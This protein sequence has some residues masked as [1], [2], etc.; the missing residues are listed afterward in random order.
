MAYNNSSGTVLLPDELLRVQ[1]VTSGILSG[2]LSYSDGADIINVPRV[3]NATNNA[4]LT[5]VDG[6]ANSLICES[7]LTFDG[8]TLTIVG[9]LTASADISGSSFHTFTTVIDETHISSSLNISGAAFYG[10]GSK[11]TGISAGGSGGGIF[12]EIDNSHAYTTSSVQI[13]STATPAHTMSVEGTSLLSGA[14]AVD[15]AITP[16]V[17]NTYDLGSSAKPWR[18]LYVSSSTI[19]LGTDTLSVG[20]DNN[21]KF[22]SGSTN[23]GFDVG[24]MNFKNTGIF[25]DPGRIFQLRAYQMRFYGGIAYVRQVVADDYSIKD[26]DYLVGIQ[27]ND[28]TASATLTL[29]VASGLINGQTFVIKDE[30]GNLHNHSVVV[31]CSASDTIDGQNTIVLESPYA[32]INI[33]CNGSNKYFIC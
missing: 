8:S 30:G 2:N 27:S 33:Y 19:Y 18:N 29:P 11:L 23:K 5:N 31:S 12:T 28:L 3:A 21:L 16:T 1:G 4:I 20:D 22:G 7:N 9:D 15:G 17:A 32:S 26:T 14:V 6:N 25:M 13:G 10:D 24:F